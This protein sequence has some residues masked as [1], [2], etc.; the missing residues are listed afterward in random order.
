MTSL[1]S[2]EGVKALAIKFMIMREGPRGFKNCPK[3]CDVINFMDHP[4]ISMI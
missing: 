2:W 4:Y 1:S 3:L